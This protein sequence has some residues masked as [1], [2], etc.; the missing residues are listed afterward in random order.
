MSSQ[1]SRA[2]LNRVCRKCVAKMGIN[3]SPRACMALAAYGMSSWCFPLLVDV[4]G[5]RINLP[6]CSIFFVEMSWMAEK[7]IC[8]SI[9]GPRAHLKKN[10]R[11]R[12]MKSTYKNFL[13]AW[14][15]TCPA[16]SLFCLFA[17]VHTWQ[18]RFW[19]RDPIS[20]LED[21]IGIP[22]MTC[23]AHFN[24]F[25]MSENGYWK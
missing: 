5:L 23:E 11:D 4:V 7:P 6:K 3:I 20:Q 13:F 22:G 16:T 25:H 24:I 12:S 14:Q 18:Y 8:W 9:V 21:G 1:W 2:W 10:I 17:W 15:I 19:W